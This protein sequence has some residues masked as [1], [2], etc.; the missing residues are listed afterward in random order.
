MTQ[1]PRIDDN[2]SVTLDRWSPGL[3][4]LTL[5]AKPR[6]TTVLVG[7]DITIYKLLAELA[8]DRGHRGRKT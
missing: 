5:K 2:A 4:R 7:R 8:R 1:L 3:V 6:G